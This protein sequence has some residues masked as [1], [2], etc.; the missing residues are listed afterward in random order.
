VDARH[1]A[2]HDE[3]QDAQR[4]FASHPEDREAKDKQ[5]QKDHDEDIKQETGDIRR[6]GRYAGE[7]E[8]AGDNR[9]QEEDQRPL[10]N[11]HCLFLQLPPPI[12]GL[13]KSLI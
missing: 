12:G 2:G 10:Q 7:T 9:H 4:R 6:R 1:K 11:C 8:Q 13:A 5:D 3:P